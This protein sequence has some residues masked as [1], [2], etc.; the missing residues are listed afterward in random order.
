MI[1]TK[2][3]GLVNSRFEMSIKSSLNDFLLQLLKSSVEISSYVYTK[4]IILFHLDE[5][6]QNHDLPR[7][8]TPS[9]YPATI[10][11]DFKE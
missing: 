6:W 8:F 4:T 10:H 9:K 2:Q 5:Q 3:N 11:L 7:R 1:Q